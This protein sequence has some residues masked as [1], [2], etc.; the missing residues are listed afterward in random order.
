MS[1]VKVLHIIKS[2]GRG[3]AET[4]LQETL[5]K[6]DKEK[7]EFH[8]IYFLP[9]KNQMVDTITKE[10]GIVNLFSS[11]NNIII[12]LQI[13]KILKYIKVNN[14]EIIHCHLPW[15]GFVGRMV[16][17][18]QKKPVLYTE[19]NIQQRYHW[20]TRLLNKLSYNFQ[21]K[22]IAVSSDVAK[23]IQQSVSP[24]IPVV[25]IAN[26]VDTDLFVR[27]PLLRTEKRKD[28][29]ID[30]NTILIGNIAVFRTQK[31]LI[32]WITIFDTIHH[33][34]PEVK[35]CIIGDGICK[36]EIFS[37]VRKLN[38][39][40]HIF[41]PGLQTDVLPWLSSMDIFMMSSEFEGLPIALL[42]AMSTGCAI[43]STDAGGIKEVIRNGIDGLLVHVED[44]KKLEN[45]LIFLLQ[46][47]NEI[48]RYGANARLRAKELFSIEKMVKAIEFEYQNVLNY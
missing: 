24:K 23:S 34:F 43:V 48:T 20:I 27:N 22:T 37:Y 6:H 15:A 30:A 21:T 25:T 29:N 47:P 16:F 35:G 13:F 8:Y 39:E 41:F 31:R 14:I 10:G 28:L 26:G 44:W 2:L 11:K 18:L 1:K 7:Y 4:L 3:G 32:E 19:H 46:H 9:W 45:P 38:L 36:D 42:E 33:Q 5:K 12:L 17:L 40:E